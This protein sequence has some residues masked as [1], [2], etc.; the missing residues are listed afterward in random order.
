MP[1]LFDLPQHHSDHERDHDGVHMD[2]GARAPVRYGEQ[3]E[4]VLAQVTEDALDRPAEGLGNLCFV[5]S[6]S[7]RFLPLL[8]QPPA[9]ADDA[10]RALSVVF[11]LGPTRAIGGLL[12]VVDPALCP[13]HV[14]VALPGPTLLLETDEL[15][16]R[17]VALV[18]E[19]N[20]QCIL[21]HLLREAIARSA[22]VPEREAGSD[23]I[24]QA[25]RLPLAG[26]EGPREL[27]ALL[28]FAVS[29]RVPRVVEPGREQH[30]LAFS[31]VQLVALCD[32]LAGVDELAAPLVP[33]I[34]ERRVG[35]RLLEQLEDMLSGE[36]HDVRIVLS[37][38]G[39][40]TGPR[41]CGT[42]PRT[43]PGGRPA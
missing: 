10:F 34:E 17:D 18:G 36:P 29:C 21:Q 1:V 43:T 33:A 31:A 39:P 4:L 15:G 19:R 37:H 28:A 11:E 35:V 5:C 42:T 24:G 14:G 38:S 6:M 13:L 16:F 40:A 27:D 32:L 23:R 20:E 7:G 12:E 30:D 2:H 8:P 41:E 22:A 25:L 3:F 26:E 9:K